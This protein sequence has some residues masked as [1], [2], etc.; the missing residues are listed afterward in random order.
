MKENYIFIWFN[1]LLNIE[2]RLIVVVGNY[3]NFI[4]CIFCFIL[5]IFIYL[6]GWWLLECWYM[7]ILI[8]LE[9]KIV[10]YIYGWFGMLNDDFCLVGKVKMVCLFLIS[11]LKLI[12]NVKL[13]I[14]MR[15]DFYRKY[16]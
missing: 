11:I 10:L 6:K 13:I 4:Y 3:G 9:E 16:C 14:G 12:I 15:L 2:V 1:K 7:D 8:N 5:K